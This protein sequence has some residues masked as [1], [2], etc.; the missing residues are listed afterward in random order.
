[1]EW[2]EKDLAKLGRVGDRTAVVIRARD[3]WVKRRFRSP[4]S[5]EGRIVG[6]GWVFFEDPGC[7]G[8]ITADKRIFTAEKTG[9]GVSREYVLTP[10]SSLGGELVRDDE[11]RLVAQ[12]LRRHHRR[13]LDMLDG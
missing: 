13:T 2:I 4:V 7:V 12:R 3:R 10:G 1:M 6:T 9:A 8:V 5:E 11:L